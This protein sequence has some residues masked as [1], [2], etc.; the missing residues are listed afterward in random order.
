[1]CQ[2]AFS[3]TLSPSFSNLVDATK[4]FTCCNVRT[5]EPLIE[6][7]LH[8]RGH[9]DRAG[10]PC[11]SLQTDNGPVLLTLLNVAE[12]QFHCLTAPHAT[13]EQARPEVLDPVF[14]SSAH[15][16]VP[17]TISCDCS[18][19]SQFPSLTPI[20]LT[21]FTRRIPAARSG[22]RRPHSAA[23]SA[24]LSHFTVSASFGKNEILALFCMLHLQHRYAVMP[25]WRCL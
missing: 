9:R 25:T 7:L 14:R 13:R 21:P 12:I 4:H 6:S 8:S 5:L 19:V 3:V 16:L 24:Y 2:T 22:L 15:H 11:L 17:A 20:F 1:M 10:R 18:A 23:S